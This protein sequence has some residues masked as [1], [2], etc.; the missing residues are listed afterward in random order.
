MHVFIPHTL[1]YP[2]QRS[3]HDRQH[4]PRPTVY[5]WQYQACTHMQSRTRTLNMLHVQST[6]V[7][8][9]RV[10]LEDSFMPCVQFSLM[11]CVALRA[12]AT[13]FIQSTISAPKQ[14]LVNYM[15][16]MLYALLAS[17]PSHLTAPALLWLLLC[18][19][20]TDSLYAKIA[21][22]MLDDASF[23]CSPVMEII[24]KHSCKTHKYLPTEDTSITTRG[25]AKWN[26]K[27][28]MISIFIWFHFHKKNLHL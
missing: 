23:C 17:L 7:R 20:S 2:T 11:Q 9:T 18:Y 21:T 22:K 4:R 14:E 1:P 15:S 5:N 16:C 24:S 19:T 10:Y 25:W 13:S 26:L 27:H 3:T 8:C 12:F 28:S 6:C